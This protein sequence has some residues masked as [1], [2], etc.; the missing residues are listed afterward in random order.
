MAEGENGLTVQVYE[1]RLKQLA[2]EKGRGKDSQVRALMQTVELAYHGGLDLTKHKHGDGRDDALKYAEMYVNTQAGAQV[3]DSKLDSHQ[4]TASCFRA[5]I[6]VGGKSGLGQGEPL[7]G[8]GQLLDIRRQIAKK[9]GNKAVDDAANTLL[10]WA[11]LQGNANRAFGEEELREIARKKV[12]D[13]KTAAEIISGARGVLQKLAK[14]LAANGNASDQS[15]EVQDAI[16]NLT[17]RLVNI[18]KEKAN[19]SQGVVP[20]TPAP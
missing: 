1:E 18:A 7:S 20:P 3:F 19:G 16:G 17:T 2:G 11:R 15:Q 9:Q 13:I 8:M 10:R 4:K 12:P 6:K 5:C 14:G